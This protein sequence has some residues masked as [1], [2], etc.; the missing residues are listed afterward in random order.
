MKKKT[1]QSISTQ[2][3]ECEQFFGINNCFAFPKVEKPIPTEIKKGEF[4]H[5]KKH[6]EQTNNVL[7]KEIKL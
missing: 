1:H 4:V 7:Y 5:T 6:P 3:Y 2:C